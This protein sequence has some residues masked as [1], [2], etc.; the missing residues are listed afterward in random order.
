[1]TTT[2]QD[3][4]QTMQSLQSLQSLIEAL[5]FSS[6]KPITVKEL[7]TI[8]GDA[9]G[10]EINEVLNGIKLKYQDASHGIYLEEV[11][12]GVHFRTKLDK[13]PWIKKML[14]SKPQRM[15]RAQLETLAIVAYKQP[16]TRIDID[17]I[18][19]V[20]SSHL[21]KVLLDKKLIKIVGVKEA[22][23]RPLIYSTTDEFLEFFN[24]NQ[25]KDLPSLEQLKELKGRTTE[26]LPLFAKDSVKDSK[27][28][29]DMKELTLQ[30][31]QDLPDPEVQS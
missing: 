23:G 29:L 20:D 11:A 5:I 25:V 30:T 10:E 2:P 3:N 13:A 18:R 22:P 8:I 19:G 6:D 7:L 15:S 24:L 1:M 21:L 4:L 14:A 17:G 28:I 31:L 26:S 9:S 12:G 16:V 27:D